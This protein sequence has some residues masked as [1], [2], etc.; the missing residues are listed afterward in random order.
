MKGTRLTHLLVLMSIAASAFG[1]VPSEQLVIA[2]VSVID[3]ITGTALPARN[4]VI[5]RDRIVSV[6]DGSVE[7]KKDAT[8]ID[9]RGKYSIP[10]LWDVHVHLSWTSESAL[11]LLVALGITDVR[12]MGGSLVEIDD[13]R[14]RFAL[15]RGAASCRLMPA[16][17]N[18]A[19]AG[20][21]SSAGSPGVI[22]FGMEIL[23]PTRRQMALIPETRY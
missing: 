11:P 16:G 8:V 20:L 21:Y 7:P 9:G 13:W 1:H 4:V 14:K 19:E 12:D 2:H 10:G 15:L 5:D 3:V 22:S 18:G 23:L 6:E 17:A